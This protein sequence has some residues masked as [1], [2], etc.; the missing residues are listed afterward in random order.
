MKTLK[1]DNKIIRI[2]ENK[3]DECLNVGYRFCPKSEWKKNVRD[4]SMKKKKKKE[5]KS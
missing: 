4:V 5:K 3:V 1:K 2:K